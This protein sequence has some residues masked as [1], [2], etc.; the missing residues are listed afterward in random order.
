M[1]R[2]VPGRVLPPTV[3]APRPAPGAKTQSNMC[4]GAVRSDL[5]NGGARVGMSA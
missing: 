4:G 1:E 2:I 5:T 3:P